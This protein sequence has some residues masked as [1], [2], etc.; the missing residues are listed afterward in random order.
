M[1]INVL[2]P[3]TNLYGAVFIPDRVIDA[4]ETLVIGCMNAKLGWILGG[5]RTRHG[6]RRAIEEILITC[7]LPVTNVLL[8]WVIHDIASSCS[9]INIDVRS[10][11]FVMS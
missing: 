10:G 8:I 2:S 4:D 7:I 11:I 9:V 3:N 5:N 1:T 6:W